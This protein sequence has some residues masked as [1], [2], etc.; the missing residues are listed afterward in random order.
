MIGK[1][2]RYYRRHGPARFG[3]RVAQKLLGMRPRDPAAPAGSQPPLYHW[4]LP[5]RTTCGTGDVVVLAAPGAAP[6]GAID[7][8]DTQAA[9][10]LILAGRVS[11][12]VV[13]LREHDAALRDL[14]RLAHDRGIATAALLPAACDAGLERPGAGTTRRAAWTGRRGPGA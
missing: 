2:Y 5:A 9:A 13:E 1:A 11:T 14:L 3:L 8:P 6:S 10:D 4:P 12:L 7:V